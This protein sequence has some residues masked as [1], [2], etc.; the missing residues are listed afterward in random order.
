MHIL[1]GTERATILPSKEVD[2]A[3]QY[4]PRQRVVQHLASQAPVESV[5]TAAAAAAAAAAEA[6]AAATLAALA[7]PVAAQVASGIEA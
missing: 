6:V 3:G 2:Q 7:A 5:A 1:M 4:Q